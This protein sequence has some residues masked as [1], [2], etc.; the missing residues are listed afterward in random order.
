MLVGLLVIICDV[1]VSVLV[2]ILVMLVVVLKVQHVWRGW[3]ESRTVPL[4]PDGGECAH[5]LT[6]SDPS[7]EL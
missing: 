4:F 6:R 3:V 7:R 5:C 1:D 2:A